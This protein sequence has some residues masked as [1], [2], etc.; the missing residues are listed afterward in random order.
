ML[1][2]AADICHRRIPLLVTITG[3]STLLAVKE[4]EDTVKAGANAINIMPPSFGFPNNEM[5]TSH[6]IEV[7]RA[8]PVPVM[9]QYAPAL[10]G[11]VISNET[12]ERISDC[13]NK[14]LYIKVEANPTG[15]VITS[16]ISSTS[17]FAKK[18]S[19]RLNNDK[20]ATAECMI[21]M[22]KYVDFNIDFFPDAGCF[23]AVQRLH[24]HAADA[25]RI[26]ADEPHFNQ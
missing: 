9:I 20:I 3:H 10:T 5:I 15:P 18:N 24:M 23:P 12:F 21:E 6:I 25:Y 7:A 1:R 2:I 4:A 22:K 13:A 16:I 11:G 17:P 26:G 19:V 8:V 14:E